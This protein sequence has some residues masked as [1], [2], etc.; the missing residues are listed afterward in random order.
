[1]ARRTISLPA[2]PPVPLAL[3]VPRTEAVTKLQQ[4]IDLGKELQAKQLHFR[5]A[6]DAYG[7]EARSLSDY[8]EELLKRLRQ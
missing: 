5:E 7:K 2:P 4:R 3:A 6:Y 8:N 1:M